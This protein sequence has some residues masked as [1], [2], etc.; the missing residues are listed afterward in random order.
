MS[1]DQKE[2]SAKVPVPKAARLIC[3]VILFGT[4]MGIR[5]EFHSIWIRALVAGCAF[6]VLGLLVLPF[7]KQRE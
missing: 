5:T 1:D 4:L 6:A 2:E 3:G 7:R